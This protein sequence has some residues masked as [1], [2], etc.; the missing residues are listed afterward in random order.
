MSFQNAEAN[1]IIMGNVS[2]FCGATEVGMIVGDL[3]FDDGTKVVG[4]KAA[5]TGDAEV[6]LFLK[7]G[8]L[9][10]KLSLITLDPEDTKMVYTAMLYTTGA[11]GSGI[12]SSSRAA[13]ALKENVWT[14]V[15]NGVGA[16]GTVYDEF[17]MHPKSVQI[18]RG[19]AVNGY[20]FKISEDNPFKSE[21]ELMGLP[22]LDRLDYA[23]FEQSPNIVLPAPSGMFINTT[24]PGVA[25]TA[26]PTTITC[27][28]LTG[29]VFTSQIISGTLNVI[30]TTPGT[31]LNSFKGTFQPL[32]ITG[33]T[34]TTP[35]TATV[36]I[37]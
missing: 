8:N 6:R 30:M 21:I 33:G 37:G 34:S 22:D 35:A 12:R 7:T 4:S 14:L 25:Y 31:A 2:V 11:K 19:V 20:G 17:N 18:Y 28:A 36:Y 16:D 26:V 9:K 24:F 5:Q 32:V 29:S 13:K 3:V 15:I 1:K 27:A 10:T 23:S